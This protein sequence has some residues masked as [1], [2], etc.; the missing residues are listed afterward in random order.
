MSYTLNH[1]LKVAEHYDPSELAEG[2]GALHT[3]DLNGMVKPKNRE[4]I[5]SL[6]GQHQ[7]KGTLSPKQSYW[8]FKLMRECLGLN[9]DALDVAATP[10]SK[11]ERPINFDAVF[12]MFV[13]AGKHLKKPGV[14]FPDAVDSAYGKKSIKVYPGYKGDSLNVVVKDNYPGKV[15]WIGATSVFNWKYNVNLTDNQKAQVMDLMKQFA[16][17]PMGTVAKYGKLANR[18]CFCSKELTDEKSVSAGY[19]QICGGHYNLPWG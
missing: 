18:C 6:I 10:E 19:G 16:A 5:L 7:K 2:I 3:F 17:D 13:E 15:A 9:E 1:D 4:F 12:D 8:V 14:V 11:V